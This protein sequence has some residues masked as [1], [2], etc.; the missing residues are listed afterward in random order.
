MINI[1]VSIIV[2]NTVIDKSYIM[3]NSLQ[4]TPSHV[5]LKIVSTE[6]EICCNNLNIIIT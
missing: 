4:G 6:S 3:S 2:K 1:M 5:G